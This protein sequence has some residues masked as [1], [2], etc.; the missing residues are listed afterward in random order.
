MAKDRENIEVW[1]ST[2][3]SWYGKRNLCSGER[4]W[5]MK[6]KWGQGRW[7]WQYR[8]VRNGVLLIW[9]LWKADDS[10]NGQTFEWGRNKGTPVMLFSVRRD[11]WSFKLHHLPVLWLGICPIWQ[12]FCCLTTC[13][14]VYLYIY[15]GAGSNFRIISS[16]DSHVYGVE[17][18]TFL[19]TFKQFLPPRI[20]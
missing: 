15:G 18:G 11:N 6:W 1:L 9:T 19:A 5:H 16:V 17:W 12:L 8:L 13:C 10:V 4:R 7:W 2:G 14:N 3:D 20:N